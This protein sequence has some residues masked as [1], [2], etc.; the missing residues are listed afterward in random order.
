MVIE[1]KIQEL[2]DKREQARLG[3]GQKRIDSQHA[4]GKY[5][6]R[7]RIAMLLDEGSFEEFDMFLTHRT[8]DFGLD[9][10]QY[11]GDGVVTGYGTIDGR[12][13]YVYAQDFTLI[14][15]R[16]CGINDLKRVSEEKILNSYVAYNALC[17]GIARSVLANREVVN[18]D[19]TA[20][21]GVEI[22]ERLCFFLVEVGNSYKNLFYAEMLYHLKRSLVLVIDLE[23]LNDAS[24]LIF[25]S[26]EEAYRSIYGTLVIYQLVCKKR[27]YLS[28]TDYRNGNFVS[29][30]FRTG[31]VL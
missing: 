25:I 21:L 8:T 30:I 27:A 29:G 10:Q 13:V 7:E 6:A 17:I 31:R 12:V 20:R 24:Y 26:V 11:L 4:K 18:L 5:T 22:E 1:Q 23:P 3:G 16:G 19:L 14:E 15:I 28:R 9:K 2:L